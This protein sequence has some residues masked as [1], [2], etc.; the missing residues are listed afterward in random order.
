MTLYRSLSPASLKV[1]RALM[2]ATFAWSSC[3]NHPVEKTNALPSLV[4][5]K[6]ANPR[7]LP[8]FFYQHLERDITDL[9]G[10]TGKNF[11]EATFVL[12]LIVK[13]IMQSTGEQCEFE[14]LSEWFMHFFHSINNTTHILVHFRSCNTINY[15]LKF[16]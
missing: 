4:I 7:D 8:T 5:S 10:L 3:S 13:S 1:L 9:A 15:L 16:H 14:E 11:E 6:L 2:H 12:H